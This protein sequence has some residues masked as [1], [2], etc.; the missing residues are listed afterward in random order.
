MRVVKTL[1]LIA[2]VCAMIYAI[3]SA[4]AVACGMVGIARGTVQTLIGIVVFGALLE[5]EGDE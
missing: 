4:G 1:R 5:D 2:A 3:G